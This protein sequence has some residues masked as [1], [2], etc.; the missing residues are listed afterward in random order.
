VNADV[1]VTGETGTGKEQVAQALH[2]S[3]PRGDQ[4]FVPVNCGALTE[5]IIESD[6]FSHEKGAF[7]GADQT[8]IGKFEY[9]AGGTIFLDEIESMPLDLQVRLLRVLEERKIVHLGSKIEIPFN[10]QIIAACKGNLRDAVS[11]GSFRENLYYR[12]NVLA[13]SIPL[14]RDR[15]DDI[16]LLVTHFINQKRIQVDRVVDDIPLPEMKPLMSYGSPG[17]VREL[18][19]SVRRYVLGQ[20]IELGSP[21]NDEELG[22]SRKTLYDKLK[23]YRLGNLD[24]KSEGD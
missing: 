15:L 20:R 22:V 7:T 10:V 18:R 9:A 6:L 24:D 13:V 2:K 17:N 1:L 5:T 12:L 21:D 23:K 11:A 16:P 8:R 19:N 3:S 14:L 4:R